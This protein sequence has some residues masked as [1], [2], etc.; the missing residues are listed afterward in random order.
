MFLFFQLHSQLTCSKPNCS[1][2]R[3]SSPPL[4]HMACISPVF[5]SL[6]L[7]QITMQPSSNSLQHVI[8]CSKNARRLTNCLKFRQI[9]IEHT[10]TFFNET[11][12][13]VYIYITE[14]YHAFNSFSHASF[15]D[16]QFIPLYKNSLFT[17]S[18]ITFMRFV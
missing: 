3:I 17:H 15:Y 14:K 6:F 4:C 16:F 9:Y 11:F 12:V 18:C 13:C 10:K 1:Y 5:V 7:V 2:T 8:I